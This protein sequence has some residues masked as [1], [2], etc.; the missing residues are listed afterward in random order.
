MARRTVAALALG[1]AVAVGWTG[2]VRAVAPPERV[3]VV[4]ATDLGP[5][6]VIGSGDVREVRV[7]G[8]DAAALASVP[9]V[10]DAL[11]H[12]LGRPVGAGEVVS[13]ASL[14]ARGLLPPGDT[15]RALWLPAASVGALTGV[16]PGSR[17]D[18]HAVGSARPLLRAVAVLSVTHDTPGG[19][20]TLTGGPG[21]PPGAVLAVPEAEVD[22]VF[23]GGRLA[24]DVTGFHFAVL[25]P[26]H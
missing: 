8:A 23:A 7:G 18:V 4:A 13:T 9:S 19:V 20:T 2:L 12:A 3:V 11:G 21:T 15:R 24:T 1:G 6:D 16:S 25:A 17:V 10:A 14:A 22:E 5:G 26:R